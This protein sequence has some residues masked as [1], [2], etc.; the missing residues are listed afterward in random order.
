LIAIFAA[1]IPTALTL[2]H[3]GN[4]TVVNASPTETPRNVRIMHR[5]NSSVR[6]T[7][8][9]QKSQ[10]GLIRYSYTQ[11]GKI[12]TQMAGSIHTRTISHEVVLTDLL[13]NIQ[14]SI[15]ILSGDHWYTNGAD[16][17]QFI[18]HKNGP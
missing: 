16:P 18:F 2:I 3:R 10:P 7:W 15:E 1:A 6:V 5:D 9:T 8:E 13:P 12:H 4:D 11:T 14:Y 17:I